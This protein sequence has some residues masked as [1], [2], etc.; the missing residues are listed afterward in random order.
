MTR[1]AE[2]QARANAATEG[3]WRA[4]DN[5][6]GTVYD[7]RNIGVCSMWAVRRPADAVF[8]A[9]A[10]EDIPWLLVRVQELEGELRL[11]NEEIRIR[12]E[13]QIPVIPRAAQRDLERANKRWNDA[14]RELARTREALQGLFNASREYITHRDTGLREKWDVARAVLVSAGTP[15]EVRMAL[16]DPDDWE[17][18]AACDGDE[19]GWPCSCVPNDRGEVYDESGYPGLAGLEAIKAA[20]PWTKAARKRLGQLQRHPGHDGPSVCAC[21]ECVLV[22]LL[23][24]AFGQIEYDAALGSAGTRDEASS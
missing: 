9:H 8:I 11:A 18:F 6:K 13:S 7:G 16:G 14:E 24:S 21:T 19:V 2:I 1:L 20:T 23:E 17:H 12:E 4:N 10:R 15:P 3:P 22:T 5:G